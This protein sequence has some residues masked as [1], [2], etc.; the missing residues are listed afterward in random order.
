MWLR[1]HPEPRAH[2][3]RVTVSR[4]TKLLQPSWSS[5][6]VSSL[7]MVHDPSDRRPRLIRP[8]RPLRPL[9]L[10]GRV[11]SSYS[12]YSL[13]TCVR[14][15]TPWHLGLGRG[16]AATLVEF[17]VGANGAASFNIPASVP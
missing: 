10:V 9:Q 7:V 14:D 5:T 16:C 4:D 3:L 8:L 12:R 15:R 11:T 17:A 13:S 1:T 6:H 2:Y